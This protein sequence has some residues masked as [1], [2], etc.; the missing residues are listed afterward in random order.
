MLACQE[1]ASCR[2]YSAEEK[3]TYRTITWAPVLWLMAS[4][5]LKMYMTHDGL[6]GPIVIAGEWSFF[7]NKQAECCG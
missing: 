6:K 3:N 5:K 7:S 1:V 2:R 4:E